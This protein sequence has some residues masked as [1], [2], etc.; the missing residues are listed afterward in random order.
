MLSHDARA[1]LLAIAKAKKLTARGI[2]SLV[3]IARAIAD[4]AQCEALAREHLLEASLFH[5][6][7]REQ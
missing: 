6:G 5:G 4:M 7:E 1:A 2:A 3:R